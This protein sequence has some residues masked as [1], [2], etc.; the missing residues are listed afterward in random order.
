MR[1]IKGK[2][3]SILL[4]AWLLVFPCCVQ[5]SDIVIPEG[6]TVIEAEAFANCSAI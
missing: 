6:T 2:R 3:M 1:R 5:A 4:T